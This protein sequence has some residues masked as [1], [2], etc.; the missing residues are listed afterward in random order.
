MFTQELEKVRTDAAEV[1]ADGTWEAIADA[2]ASIVERMRGNNRGRTPAH[3]IGREIDARHWVHS[4]WSK[5]KT[6]RRP[7][8]PEVAS[9]T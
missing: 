7:V 8:L 4:S 2:N 5:R 1:T 9:T 6:P 3:A